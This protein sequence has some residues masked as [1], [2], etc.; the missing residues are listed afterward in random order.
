MKYKGYEAIVEF[1][2]EADIFHGEVINIR[3]VITFQGSSVEELKKAFHDSVDDYLEFCQERGEEPDKPFSG[4]FVV[5]INPQ[6]HQIITIRAK[7]E[8]KSLNSWIE[9]CLSEYT[10]KSGYSH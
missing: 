6:L 1:D 9:K 5:R 2:D 3:D 7:K 4:K 8:G 10:G